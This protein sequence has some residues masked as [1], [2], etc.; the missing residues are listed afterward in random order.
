MI[1]GIDVGGTHTDGVLLGINS[2]NGEGYE[3]LA[4]SKVRTQK[5][6]LM[7][8]ILEVLDVLLAAAQVPD[9]KRIVLSTTLAANVIVE[10]NYD[11]VGLV[12]IPGPGLN[13]EHLLIGDENILLSGYINHRGIEVRDLEQEELLKGLERI[14]ARGIKNLAIVS[15]FSTRNPGLEAEVLQL[16]REKDYP[17]EN[18][19]LGHQLSGRLGFPRRL[20][21]AY[22]NTA[23]MSVYRD[24]VQAVEKALEERELDTGVF[25]L[26]CDGGTVPLD[27][28]MEA[29]IET[30][31]SGPAA[32]IMGTMAMTGVYQNKETA[33]ALDIGGTTTDI[34]LFIKGEPAFMPEGIELN[35]FPTLVRGLYSLSLPLGG[36]SK[37]AVKDGKLKIGPERDGPAAA[38][39]GPSP[40]PTD[41]LLVLDYIQDDPDYE[42][43]ADLQAAREALV[44]LAGD[45]DPTE[46]GRCRQDGKLDLTEFASFIIDKMLASIVE[47]IQEILASLENKPVYTISELLAG[48]EIRPQLLLTMGGPASA[49]SPL[50]AEK[51]GYREEVVPYAKVANAVGAALARP[52]LQT[53]VR[54]DTAA[55]YLHI[56]EAGI[57]RQLKAG[58][59]YDLEE[60]EELAMAWTRKRADDETA[61][62][63]IS[64]R[65]SFNVIRGFRTIG[66]IMEVRAQIKP[67]LISRP[68]GSEN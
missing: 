5:D 67:G 48:V 8:S 19:S 13:P 35:G 4:T 57:H 64:E 61:V 18:I 27:R 54:V 26:K 51:L 59:D 10:E 31:N 7:K 46:Y 49:L 42:G 36:D 21:T 22:F 23:I 25:V 33:I 66:K 63:E 47:T 2:P 20:V 50:L 34:G 62:V 60:V 58:E 32:S 37:I 12:L 41:A 11:P 55:S 30:V 39:G 53:T 9:I 65:E 16:I 6:N 17:F 56:V 14:K 1:I 28:V 3:I 15:K 45:L 38:F 68:E 43:R 44:A 24:F 52:T 40:T 29:P